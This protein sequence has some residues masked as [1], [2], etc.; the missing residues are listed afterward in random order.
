MSRIVITG[1]VVLTA[2]DDSPVLR[3]V[4]VVIEDDTIVSIAPGAETTG[5]EVIDASGSIVMP[6]LIDTHLH[7]WEYGWR[8]TVMR[9]NGP[10]DYMKLLFQT[11]A[12]YSPQDVHDSIVG[13]G[14]ETIANGVTGVLDFMH[15]ATGTAEHTDAAVEAYRVTGQRAL[16]EIGALRANSASDEDFS[17]SRAARI[18]DVARLRDA[19]RDDGLIDVGTALI[20]P[21]PGPLWEMFVADVTESREIGARMTF[22]ANEVG[23]FREME[24]SGLLGSD[25]VPSHGNRASR[26]ELKALAEHGVVLS[27]SPHTE[28]NS[29]KSPGV[30][31]RAVEQGVKVAISIDTPP[32][33]MPLS[34]FAQLTQ[35]WA[36]VTTFDRLD[37]REGGR[38]ELDFDLDPQSFTLEDAVQAA[39]VNGA[40]ALG[41]DNLGRIAPGQLADVIVVRPT[42]AIALRD[43]AAYVVRATPHASEVSEVI[44]GGT[45]R[46][47][48]GR[49]VA[50]DSIDIPAMNA[51]SQERV[52]AMIEDR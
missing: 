24:R 27:V 47:R 11:S 2:D 34:E 29:G 20:T 44:I 46:K 8:G 52:L 38:Y 45:V 32:S 5:A 41:Y 18:A 40:V 19:T 3:D 31:I 15:G 28:I 25:I 21:R 7:A 17:Q 4:D 14:L 13:A 30:F 6:G 50:A 48:G 43:P 10:V 1:G 36:S 26:H 16:L 9:K 35:L 49:L 23:E 12:G 22:H 33:I 37:A 42:D 51:R 39:T